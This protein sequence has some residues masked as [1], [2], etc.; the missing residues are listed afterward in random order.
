MRRV[1]LHKGCVSINSNNINSY[2][3][4]EH[5]G[6]THLA[7]PTY[8]TTRFTVRT[9][10]SRV[11]LLAGVVLS[12]RFSGLLLNL[13]WLL[14]RLLERPF[15]KRNGVFCLGSCGRLTHRLGCGFPQPDREGGLGSCLFVISI[16]PSLRSGGE[17]TAVK[18][19]PA[20]RCAAGFT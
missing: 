16:F 20:C 17:A 6:T 1:L 7:V 3:I 18:P 10:D 12:A 11:F 15:Q 8:S 2:V 4:T 13:S 9:Q 5:T 14:H 19:V